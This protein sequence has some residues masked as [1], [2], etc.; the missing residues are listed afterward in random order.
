MYK[1]HTPETR[2]CSLK[3]LQESDTHYRVLHGGLHRE[4]VRRQL[5][6][7]Q[8]VNGEVSTVF[9]FFLVLKKTLKK[10]PLSPGERDALASESAA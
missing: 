7:P 8:H 5:R 1:V 3:H 6:L 4:A 9:F 2:I 10:V